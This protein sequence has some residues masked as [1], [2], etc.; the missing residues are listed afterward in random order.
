MQSSMPLYL[1]AFHM[2]LPKSPVVQAV[3]GLVLLVVG[4]DIRLR[5]RFHDGSP[6]EWQ[7]SLASYG[8]NREAL[9]ITSSGNL[10]AKTHIKWI[11]LRQ[12]KEKAMVEGREFDGIECPGQLDVFFRRGGNLNS[13]A[14]NRMLRE[15]L[16]TRYVR[17]VYVKVL[18]NK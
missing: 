17:S 15:I 9:P 10:K 16:L 11:A 3:R 18:V 1:S 6:I 13:H 5:T 8:I 12:A 7:Y 2:L 14:G 4:K